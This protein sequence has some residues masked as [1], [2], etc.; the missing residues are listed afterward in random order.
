[1]R[2]RCRAKTD[3][4]PA[5]LAAAG[6][7]MTLDITQ[8]VPLSNTAQT[9]G[10]ALN[11]ARA[12]GFGNWSIDVPTMTI[13]LFGADGTTPVHSLVWNDANDPTSRN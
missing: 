8:S 10:D 12:E 6:D 2:I 13:T 4:R 3:N 11:A 5:N 1:M 9:V 7:R